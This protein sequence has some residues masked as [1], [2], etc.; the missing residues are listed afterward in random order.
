MSVRLSQKLFFFSSISYIWFERDYFSLERDNFSLERE[1]FSL[2]RDKKNHLNVALKR[3][4]N[5]GIFLE[6]V[7]VRHK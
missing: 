1:N 3:L 5:C 2:E 7:Y 6:K 4:R